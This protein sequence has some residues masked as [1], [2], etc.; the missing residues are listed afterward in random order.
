MCGF[1]GIFRF[2]DSPP[3][4]NDA[5]LLAPA[6]AVL[7]PR[8]P[9][10]IDGYSDNRCSLLHTR[11]AV[12]D[13]ADGR[14][15]MTAPPRPDR[16]EGALTVAFN[17][18]IY[19]HHELRNR[20]TSLNHRF[21]TDHA[22]TE[23]ILHGYR[24]WGGRSVTYLQ[25]MFAFA[26]WD[27]DKQQLTLAR[28]RI[29]KKPL[30][31]TIDH[32]RIL[33]A[34][35]AA[36]ILA[37]ENKPRDINPQALTQYLSLGYSTHDTLRQ[38]VRELPA[39]HMLTV[40]ADGSHQLERYWQPPPLSRTDTAYGGVEA[41]QRVLTNAIDARLEAD[42]PLGCF[43]SGGVDSSIIAAIAQ[44]LLAQRGASP[45]QTFS[46]A[47]PDARYDESHHA[48][49]AAEHIGAQHHQ[50]TA[51]PDLENDLVRLTQLT[52]EPLA[53]S[54]ILPTYWLS[55]AARKHVTVALSGDGGDEL[56]AG[57][58][59][60]HA[61]RFLHRYRR[62]LCAVP[63]SLLPKAPHQKSRLAKLKRLALAARQP[64]ANRQYR[65]IINL[66]SPEQLA[67]LLP[68][69]PPPQPLP[70][71]PD[72]PPQDAARR[73]DLHHYLPF[74]LLRK[75]DRASMAASLEVRSPML[76]TAVV[77]LASHLPHRV[78]APRGRSKHLLKQLA[79]P[80]LPVSIINR[81]K[82]GFAIPLDTWF[83]NDL[84]P[85]LQKNLL[86]ATLLTDLGFQ[87][88]ALEQLINDH[89]NRAADHTHRLFALLALAIY[90]RIFPTK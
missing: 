64:D 27:R 74:D 13:P 21:Q 35:T 79:K 14:Q 11:L 89:A 16:D 31:Y 34:S 10:D 26:L 4:S 75:A 68:D 60:Y 67:S 1:V 57:Y 45:L 52:G 5:S 7:D 65:A 83:A 15:P 18:E 71:W 86:D 77:D 50:L 17:G 6:Q 90:L 62:L 3:E 42:V 23:S 36:A 53:D 73:W 48:R 59:R 19:N 25:G 40:N 80:L 44:Q 82:M 9:D 88:P 69:A 39:A 41:V 20:L 28:D 85:T 46:V 55:R 51:E 33:F 24:Q 61:M 43:L 37:L 58:Q 72:Y 47:M 76:D 32:N 70:D 22:D 81:P 78:L 87:R 8:G 30:Y 63:A 66:F 56:F 38:G 2:N 49:A 29:G 12:L 54:S 84:K